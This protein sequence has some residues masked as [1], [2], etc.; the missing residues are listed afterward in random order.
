MDVSHPTRR[1]EG[2]R[3]THEQR[4]P[5]A[6]GESLDGHGLW[7]RSR[8]RLNP[9]CVVVQ[10]GARE[11]RLCQ[12]GAQRHRHRV[13]LRDGVLRRRLERLLHPVRVLAQRV[14][15]GL[16]RVRG[17]LRRARL[18]AQP[19]VRLEELLLLRLEGLHDLLQ[20]DAVLARLVELAPHL[21]RRRRRALRLVVDELVLAN[22]LA[23]VLRRRRERGLARARLVAQPAREALRL[24][25]LR[26]QRV[27]LRGRLGELLA[28]LLRL[29]HRPVESW[30]EELLGSRRRLGGA[31]ELCAERVQLLRLLVDLG[32]ERV[33]F[34]VEHGDRLAQLRHRSILLEERLL[35]RQPRRRLRL[36]LPP[37]RP[38]E[39]GRLLKTRRQLLAPRIEPLHES[40]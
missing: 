17:A 37:L 13:L 29:G 31:A 24:A 9:V 8:Q 30:P 21:R 15:L 1:G 32:D 38:D 36:R 5:T 6:C 40:L 11:V 22:H 14:A 16:E 2:G 33:P 18:L 39:P 27:P 12:A 26:D 20:E 3:E 35:R 19:G 10:Q 34:L 4:I 7:F 28:A 25:Q 23:Q